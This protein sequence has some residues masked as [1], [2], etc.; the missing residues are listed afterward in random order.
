MALCIA[1]SEKLH[2]PLVNTADYAYFRLRDQGYVEADIRRWADDIGTAT[3][4]LKDTFIYFKHEDEGKGP[5]FASMLRG[6][7]GA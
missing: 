3:S 2:T 5:E 7:L 1:D 4:N 6:M